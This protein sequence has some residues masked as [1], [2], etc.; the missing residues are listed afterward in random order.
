MFALPILTLN[1]FQTYLFFFPLAVLHLHWKRTFVCCCCYCAGKWKAEKEAL[2]GSAP[3]Q[4]DEVWN[5]PLT[6]DDGDG[7][8]GGD[9]GGGG[10]RG[11][12]T[13]STL[14]NSAGMLGMRLPSTMASTNGSGLERLL[15]DEVDE[16]LWDNP[17]T[18]P[19]WKWV[20]LDGPG[21]CICGESC[22]MDAASAVSR[23]GWASFSGVF[24]MFV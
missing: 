4:D 24:M 11:D 22:W 6:S 1:R 8:D 19:H 13:S 14:R 23:V 5:G 2:I 21:C 3:L 18:H 16:R 9:G 20:A 10:G 12:G 17:L 15:Q 7:G